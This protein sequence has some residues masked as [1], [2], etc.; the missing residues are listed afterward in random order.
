MMMKIPLHQMKQ[1]LMYGPPRNE[2]SLLLL[3]LMRLLNQYQRSPRPATPKQN[4]MPF[5]FYKQTDDALDRMKKNPRSNCNAFPT[6]VKNGLLW[7]WPSS[8]SDDRILSELTKI[9]NMSFEGLVDEPEDESRVLYGPWTFRYVPNGWDYVIENLIDP[10]HTAS[11]H[12]GCKCSSFVVRVLIV[13]SLQLRYITY[14]F[15]SLL[16]QWY[17]AGMWNL[18]HSMST[19]QLIRRK[20]GRVNSQ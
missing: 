14:S 5:V 15:F 9:P 13:V 8:S 1:M 12:H 6:K 7:V 2:M 16:N 10:A 19:S 20:N 18:V 11:A 17:Q 3:V 4:Q